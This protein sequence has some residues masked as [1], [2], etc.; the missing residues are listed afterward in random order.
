MAKSKKD[1]ESVAV[2]YQSVVAKTDSDCVNYLFNSSGKNGIYVETEKAS[3]Y[4]LYN[5]Y[6]EK[7]CE[8]EI[9][10]GVSKLSV[11]NCG[12]AKII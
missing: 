2:L 6:G 9:P 12:Y 10:A 5:I 8:G 7:Q 3:K 11:D 1:G 4:E